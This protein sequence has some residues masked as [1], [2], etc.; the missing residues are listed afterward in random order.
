MGKGALAAASIIFFLLCAL[1]VFYPQGTPRIVTTP[2]HLSDAGT[3]AWTFHKNTQNK[4]YAAVLGGD[5]FR[6]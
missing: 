3:K 2:F 6:P 4:A 5:F 1:H